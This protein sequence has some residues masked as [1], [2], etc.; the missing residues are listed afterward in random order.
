MITAAVE[1]LTQRLD[2]LK[3]LFPVHYQE[4]ALDQE[5]VPLDPQYRVYLER[6]GRG[7]VVFVTLR[8]AGELIGYFVG[9]IAPGLHYATCLTC[10]MDIFFVRPDKR[11]AR[12]G[13]KL[14]KAVEAELRRRGVQRWFVGSKCHKDASWL[15]EFLGF[16]QVEIYFSKWLGE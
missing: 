10:T 12:A 4:L 2:E 11:G 1:S 14:F 5:K 7:E 15:F 8:D 13:V 3:P 16:Q 6:D 9:F